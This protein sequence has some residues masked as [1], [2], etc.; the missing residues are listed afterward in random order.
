LQ[1]TAIFH[2]FPVLYVAERWQIMQASKT[3]PKVLKK[4]IEILTKQHHPNIVA[5]LG[6]CVKADELWILMDFCAFGMHV[7][8]LPIEAWLTSRFAGSLIDAIER[9][10]RC[11]DERQLA[12]VVGALLR[13]LEYLAH[14]FVVH[15]DVK[16]KRIFLASPSVLVFL[17]SS[18]FARG[19]T[20]L[21][22]GGNLLLTEEGDVKIADFGVSE[23]I[24]PSMSSPA[25]R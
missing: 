3:N 20:L 24:L 4:E 11:L 1:R 25:R 16:G 22:P 9:L 19:L 17:V 7:L 8:R 21:S 5:Y 14:N 15:R 13:G 6:S 18:L 10:D 12:S 2:A 23:G